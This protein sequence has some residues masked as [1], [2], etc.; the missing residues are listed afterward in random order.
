MRNAC[1][2]SRR[3]ISFKNKPLRDMLGVAMSHPF[4]EGWISDLDAMYGRLPAMMKMY[5]MCVCAWLARF[6]RTGSESQATA[7]VQQLIDDMNEGLR[8][9]SQKKPR[10]RSPK[11]R[12]ESRKA[13]PRGRPPRPSLA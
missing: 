1:A 3:S 6:I 11:G 4:E 9:A 10:A 8:E 13:K 7:L 12:P 5:F 2:H